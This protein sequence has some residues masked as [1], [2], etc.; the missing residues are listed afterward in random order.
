MLSLLAASVKTRPVFW[1]F[2]PWLK[3]VSYVL[4]VSSVIVFLYGVARPLVK[5]RR[6]H[7]GAWPPVAWREL[8]GRLAGGLALLL[9]QRTIGRRSRVAGVAHGGIFYGWLVLFAGTVV[10]GFETDFTAPVFGLRYFH[11]DFYLIYKET[12]NI[13]GTVLI[14][15]VI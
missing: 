15:G 12:L 7:G 2:V 11:G 14:A 8:P 10:L 4:A 6:G 3:V 5:Y 9:S 13:F 1:H